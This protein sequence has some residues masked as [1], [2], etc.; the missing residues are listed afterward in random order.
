MP[1][2]IP[3][4]CKI[5][6]LLLEIAECLKLQELTS[7][8]T[9]VYLHTVALLILIIK[10]DVAFDSDVQSVEINVNKNLTDT[11]AHST[12]NPT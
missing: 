11:Y 1:Y 10:L 9:Q 3:L 6:L 8:R 12:K 5:N 7:I 2:S 4:P